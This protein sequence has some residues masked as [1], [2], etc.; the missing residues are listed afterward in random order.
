MDCDSIQWKIGS[1]NER[2]QDQ[3][4]IL[5]DINVSVRINENVTKYL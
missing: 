2:F 3:T 1:F 4:C 5:K